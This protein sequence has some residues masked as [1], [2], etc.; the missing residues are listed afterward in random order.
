VL[1]LICENI[2]IPILNIKAWGFAVNNPLGLGLFI[3]INFIKGVSLNYLLR[4]N[5]DTRLLKPDISDND[6]KFLYKQ[7]AYILLQLFKLD[8]D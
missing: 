5:N 8:F 3:I 1:S 7:F 6:I 2:T 4:K